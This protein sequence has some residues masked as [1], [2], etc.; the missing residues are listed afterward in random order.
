M[1]YTTKSGL[2]LPPEVVEVIEQEQARQKLHKD[3]FKITNYGFFWNHTANSKVWSDIYNYDDFTEFYK[4]YPKKEV[5]KDLDSYGNEIHKGE[6]VEVR[7][8]DKH[9]WLVR[10]YFG[11]ADKALCRYLVYGSN[12]NAA[13]SYNF[14]RKITEKQSLK[15]EL[16]SQ[17]EELL[18]QAKEIEAK[19]NEL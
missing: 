10:E 17:M 3:D 11:I 16:Q 14:C 4:L 6:M 1:K 7:D 18:K 5:Q 12:Y 9:D 13:V 8:N 19:I 15:S 2:E